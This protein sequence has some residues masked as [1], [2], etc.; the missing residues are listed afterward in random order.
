MIWDDITTAS[1]KETQD[2]DALPARSKIMTKN[3]P[4]TEIKI[5][6]TPIAN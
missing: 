5:F 1:D 3:I 2:S 4:L 6:L